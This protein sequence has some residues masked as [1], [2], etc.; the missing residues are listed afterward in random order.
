MCYIVCVPV[1]VCLTSTTRTCPILT[2][3]AQKTMVLATTIKVENDG[4]S[5][6]IRRMNERMDGRTDGRIDMK[7]LWEC[8]CHIKTVYCNRVARHQ[9]IFVL[10]PLLGASPLMCLCV[11]CA[12]C[13]HW[14]TPVTI[15]R[16]LHLHSH[17]PSQSRVKISLHEYISV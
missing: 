17:T 6:W 14:H 12:L 9:R 2:D 15:Y 13:T 4:E 8:V 5:K 1:H 7:N 16:S 10:T 3:N 11:H